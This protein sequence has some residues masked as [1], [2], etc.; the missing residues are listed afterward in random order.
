MMFYSKFLFRFAVFLVLFLIP[1]FSHADIYEIRI[2]QINPDGEFYTQTCNLAEKES[3][4]RALPLPL[5]VSGKIN[6]HKIE[7]TITIDRK[8]G[9]IEANFLLDR[10]YY[11]SSDPAYYDEFQALFLGDKM[12]PRKIELFVI[13]DKYPKEPAAKPAVLKGSFFK[14]AELE[15]SVQKILP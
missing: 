9:V 1:W 11:L 6:N 7:A 15:I 2:R 13:K 14:V 10:K 8:G 12:K 3:C 5:S 4:E